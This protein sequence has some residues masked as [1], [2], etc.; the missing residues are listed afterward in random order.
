LKHNNHESNTK[1]NNRSEVKVEKE[2]PPKPIKSNSLIPI[3][4]PIDNTEE[5][6]K[7]S[8]PSDHFVNMARTISDPE[9]LKKVRKSNSIKQYLDAPRRDDPLYQDVLNILLENGYGIESW[10]P[11]CGQILA[12]QMPIYLT[13]QDLKGLGMSGVELDQRMKELME[14]KRDLKD[15]LLQTAPRTTGIHDLEL[16]EEL[17]KIPLRV[18]RNENAFGYS[19]S[20]TTEGEKIFTDD[21]CMT[22]THRHYVEKYQLSQQKN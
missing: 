2:L 13:E 15:M 14:E 20:S 6:D 17:M 19:G 22:D 16:I 3:P 7:D 21:D 9:Y 12:W 1:G 10:A 4:K 11:L 8:D 5:V 18:A